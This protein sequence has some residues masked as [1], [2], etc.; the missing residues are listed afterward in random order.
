MTSETNEEGS[1]EGRESNSPIRESTATVDDVLHTANLRGWRHWTNCLVQVPTYVQ[2][3]AE[4]I[5]QM[6]LQG[7]FSALK[8]KN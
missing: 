4:C 6:L 1:S 7:S 3:T 2:V 8:K 5:T